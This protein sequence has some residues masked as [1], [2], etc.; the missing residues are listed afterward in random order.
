MQEDGFTYV[1]LQREFIIFIRFLKNLAT[2]YLIFILP[3][4]VFQRLCNYLWISPFE[5]TQQFTIDLTIVLFIFNVLFYF[6]FLIIYFF[7]FLH[8]LLH[9]V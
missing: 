3:F 4:S 6:L 2:I 5:V 9:N 8:L 7:K 1:H